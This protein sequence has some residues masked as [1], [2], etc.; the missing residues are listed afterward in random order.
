MISQDRKRAVNVNGTVRNIRDRFA[1]LAGHCHRSAHRHTAGRCRK[2]RA[3]NIL[4]I[5]SGFHRHVRCLFH[6]PFQHGGNF[7]LQ[8]KYRNGNRNTNRSAGAC[9]G[10]NTQPVAVIGIFRIL[11]R[12]FQLFLYTC[13][14]FGSVFPVLRFLAPGLGGG[15]NI[16]ISSG[17]KHGVLLCRR[18]DI[19]VG[20]H[21][22][23]TRAYAGISSDS[24]GARDHVGI[25]IIFG[26][27][28]NISAGGHGRSIPD[29]GGYRICYRFSAAFFLTVSLLRGLFQTLIC[30]Y[31]ILWLSFIP[32]IITTGYIQHVIH[33][34]LAVAG[35]VPFQIF[36]Q[37]DA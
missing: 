14:H 32:V 17:L 9:D 15:F 20:H 5:C 13:R 1:P 36:L 11:I 12:I 18:L 28:G 6:I 34:G 2:R 30:G 8:R 31:R 16:N 27:D 26:P 10:K 35:T 7:A 37:S 22:R 23:H 3:E 24:H 33:L 19:G 21:N 4:I 25:Q 29:Q